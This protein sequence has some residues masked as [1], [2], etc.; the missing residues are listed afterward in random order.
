RSAS[1][2]IPPCRHL[3]GRQCEAGGDPSQAA[4]S[5]DRA[6]GNGPAAAQSHLPL[7]APRIAI[8]EALREAETAATLIT[9][10]SPIRRCVTLRRS[11]REGP[12]GRGL[13]EEQ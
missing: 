2:V 8:L 7:V 12:A 6:F 1:R 9:G 4:P 13:E 3:V 10:W 11:A 5:A